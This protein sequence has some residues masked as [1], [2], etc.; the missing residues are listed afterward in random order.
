MTK[1]V[2]LRISGIHMDTAEESV[3]NEPIEIFTPASYY[4]KDGTHYLFYDEVEEGV[5]GST[6][7]R[8]TLNAERVEFQKTG[9]S[10]THMIF[11]EKRKTNSV[12]ET[13]FG[14]MIMGITSGK[15]DL[16]IE[17]ES[18][19]LNMNYSLDINNQALMDCSLSIH[20]IPRKSGHSPLLWHAGD[21]PAGNSRP[22]SAV[23]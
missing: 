19:D 23:S 22:G 20:V 21:G 5:D 3:E 10:A 14:Q 16:H 18:I 4:E 11:E 12:Y 15:I 6:K 8:I 7:N 17:E 9:S 1:E 13:P 2:L